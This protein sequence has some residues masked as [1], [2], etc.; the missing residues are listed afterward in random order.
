MRV[1]SV[2]Q[3]TERAN[4]GRKRPGLSGTPDA[5]N[6]ALPPVL[7]DLVTVLWAI[8]DSFTRVVPSVQGGRVEF[9]RVHPRDLIPAV[10]PA[11]G[12]GGVV[13]VVADAATEEL[14]LGL[15]VDETLRAT[16]V[17]A[18]LSEAVAR[19]RVRAH[20]RELRERCMADQATHDGTAHMMLLGAAI[21]HE[22]NNPLAVA[23]LNTEVLHM[24]VR[25]LLEMLDEVKS[26]ADAGNP[27]P[28]PVLRRLCAARQLSPARE[29]IT[30]ALQDLEMALRDAATMVVRMTALTDTQPPGETVDLGALLGEFAQLVRAEV[31]R[32][33]RFNVQLPGPSC[34]VE[35]PRGWAM[36]I[37]ASLVANSL[38]AVADLPHRHAEIDLRLTLHEEVC[39]IEVRDNGAGMS[40]DVRRRAVEPFFTTRRPGALGLGLTMVIAQARRVGGEVLTDSRP[41]VGTTIRV[42]LPTSRKVDDR[43]GNTRLAN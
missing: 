22:M 13:A 16:H 20:A 31:E 25:S 5:F 11:L 14:A 23:S 9:A 18:A 34:F 1:G 29:D 35:I 15:G 7:G 41:G 27:M 24:S 8:D 3:N 6:V 17:D 39:V 2:A 4:R 43:V 12:R 40:T 33:A 37:A 10:V 26:Y 32:V 42:F 28:L 36:Q 21:A 38:E 30:A 19:A